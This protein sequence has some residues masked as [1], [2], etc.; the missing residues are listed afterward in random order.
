[1]LYNTVAQFCHTFAW[2]QPPLNE[3]G[4]GHWLLPADKQDAVVGAPGEHRAHG[5]LDPDW[6]L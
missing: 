4:R 2:N 5:A 3:V 6:L 1:M